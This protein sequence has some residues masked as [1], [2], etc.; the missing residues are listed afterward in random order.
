M[1]Q[2]RFLFHI[3]L[4]I[5]T[6]SLRT[7]IQ[8]PKKIMILRW[9]NYLVFS[10]THTLM[11]NYPSTMLLREY[12]R[13]KSEL[14]GV[15]TLRSISINQLLMFPLM[16]LLQFN[17]HIINMFTTMQQKMQRFWTLLRHSRMLMK[18]TMFWFLSTVS[19]VGQW[20]RFTTFLFPFKER[21][22]PF[23]TQTTTK[24]FQML[25]RKMTLQETLGLI[26]TVIF[27][28]TW[29]ELLLPERRYYSTRFM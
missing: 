26:L 3:H 20:F 2:T 4:F 16:T 29:S 6:L 13:V 1:G 5:L 21:L 25:H 22:L 27:L 18:E 9:F 19:T 24:Q 7:R 11:I 23:L 15:T 10:M 12:T 28:I 14:T 8:F 17:T